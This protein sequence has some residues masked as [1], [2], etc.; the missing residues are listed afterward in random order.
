MYSITDLHHGYEPMLNKFA[1]ITLR[2]VV[3]RET[4]LKPCLSLLLSLEVVSAFYHLKK[5]GY[6][7]MAW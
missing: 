5:K 4:I 7:E 1:F 6:W 3:L 2:L